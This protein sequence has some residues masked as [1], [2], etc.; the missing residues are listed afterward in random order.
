[1]HRTNSLIKTEAFVFIRPFNK[2]E[3]S[4]WKEGRSSLRK[5]AGPALTYPKSQRFAAAQLPLLPTP[6]C[7]TMLP[8]QNS[9]TFSE[10]LLIIHQDCQ[11]DYSFP[12][13][14]D[15]TQCKVLLLSVIVIFT[16]KQ[17]KQLLFEAQKTNSTDIVRFFFVLFWRVSD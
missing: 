4:P 11:R 14:W 12:R 2:S 15:F 8:E 7:Y 13:E 3:V 10:E 9:Q 5:P 17:L 6:H 1:V 16:E